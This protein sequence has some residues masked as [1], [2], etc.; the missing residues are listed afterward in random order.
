MRRIAALVHGWLL[1]DFFGD[2]RRSGGAGST[3]TTTIFTQSFLALVFAGLLHR[4]A[5]PVAFTAANLCLSSLLLGL[6][7]LADR[8]QQNRQSADRVLLGTAP[9]GRLEAVAARVGHQAFHV[10]F[11]SIGMALPPAVLLAWQTGVVWH[12]PAY[13]L[14]ACVCTGLATGSLGVLLRWARRLLGRARAALL[15]G[16]VKAVVFAAGLVLFA[17][18]LPA[19]RGSADSLPIGRLGAELLPPYHA[20]RLL[21]GGA[22]EA[23]RVLPLLGLACLL[24]GLGALAGEEDRAGAERIRADS[25]LRALLRRL[26]GGGPRLAVADFTAVMIWRSAGFRARVLPLLG[27]PAAMV[28]LGLGNDDRR[29]M[30]PFLCVALQLPAIYLPFLVAFLPRSDQPGAEWCF[31]H[32]PR[33]DA[34]LIQDAVGRALC[35]HVLL[36]V[37]LLLLP[38]LVLSGLPWSDAI[39]A[40]LFAA[41]IAVWMTRPMLRNLAVVPFTQAKESDANTDLGGL[42]GAALVLCVVAVAY[43]VAAPAPLRWLLAIAAAL[44]AVWMLGHRP[45]SAPTPAP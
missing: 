21:F 32:A 20:A 15:S 12:A 25:P 44:S 39:P 34:A 40:S 24:F 26:C 23:W 13:V 35:T 4:E 16:T 41:G 42:L 18:G 3:L 1:L 11:L 27:M 2:A 22:E 5:S 43:A 30:L 38:I 9:V 36:P 7:A 33:L 31:E 8:D 6:G 28:F 10:G 17:R 19:L 45:A 14:A 37:H 29:H